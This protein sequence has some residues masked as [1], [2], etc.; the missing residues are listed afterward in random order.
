VT[1]TGPAGATSVLPKAGDALTVATGG[2]GGVTE[3]GLVGAVD[4]VVFGADDSAVPGPAV[5]AVK[6][7]AVD[8][9]ASEPVEHP[10][11]KANAPISVTANHRKPC[12]FACI[13]TPPPIMSSI[14]TAAHHPA[15]GSPRAVESTISPSSVRTA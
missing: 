7:G 13:M 14:R 12:R 1:P 9:A 5:M 15:R 10:L 4:A 11:S 2:G 3:D 8:V 6:V